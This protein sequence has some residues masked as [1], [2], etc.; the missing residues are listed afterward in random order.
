LAGWLVDQMVI[1]S[2]MGSNTLLISFVT[3]HYYLSSHR[4]AVSRF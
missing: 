2:Y 1:A 3:T 4:L